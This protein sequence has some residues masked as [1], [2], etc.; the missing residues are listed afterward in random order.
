[1]RPRRCDTIAAHKEQFL[2]GKSEEFINEFE[3][4][5]EK[6]QYKAIMDWKKSAKDLG[7]ATGDLAKVTMKNVVSH[8]KDVHKK[9]K[10]LPSLSANEKV[11][12]QKYLDSVRDVIDNFDRIKKEQT[13]E[14]LQ[15]QQERLLKDNE[16][17]T[18]Q[19]ERLKSELGK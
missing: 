6:D 7:K 15:A 18:S 10:T 19:I 3:S 5:T 4:Q 13:L 16:T 11:K 1:M 12:V 14:S 9:L 17:L 2:N 8:L